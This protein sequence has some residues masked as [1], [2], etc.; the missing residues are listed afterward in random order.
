ME[1]SSRVLLVQGSPKLNSSLE[2]ILARDEI[3]VSTHLSCQDGLQNL[4]Q[5][6]PQ[7]IIIDCPSGTPPGG[8]PAL[9]RLLEAIDAQELA[10]I[11]IV[12]PTLSSALEFPEWVQKVD[13]NATSEEIWGRIQSIR[14]TQTIVRRAQLE[15]RHMQRLGRH[16]NKQFAELD[17]DM[18]L[19]S[20]LQQEFLP[21]GLPDLDGVRF[22]VLYRPATWVSGD[23]YD[24]SRVDEDHVCIYVADAVGHGMA[25]SLLTIYVT[26]ALRTKEIGSEGY[27]LLSPS[28]TLQRLNEDMVSEKL[29][30]SQFVTASYCMFNHRE[31][32]LSFARGGHPYP[33]LID[34]TGA[35]TELKTEG[36]LLGLFSGQ[37]FP[38]K[39]VQLQKGQKVIIHSDGMEQAF[40]EDRDSQTGEPRY[41]REFQKVATLPADQLT[42]QLEQ[43]MDV[44]EGSLNPRDDVTIIVLEITE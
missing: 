20:R 21:T 19:A 35:M 41:K 11:C 24:V 17:Q 23:I 10:C 15:M 5:F 8:M 12:A 34:Q 31:K 6:N 3:V 44:E 1:I 28:E 7:V 30:N 36:G 16:L 13:C 14:H 29:H 27:R 26:R 40:V 38:S 18:R 39:I 42:S 32:T 22:S 2:E 4:Q 25:A 43:I 9:T 33:I 37:E